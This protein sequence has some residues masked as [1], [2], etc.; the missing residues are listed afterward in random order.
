[1]THIILAICGVAS[2][3]Q[4]FE[5]IGGPHTSGIYTRACGNAILDQKNLPYWK[6]PADFEDT[7]IFNKEDDTIGWRIGGAYQIEIGDL[8]GVSLY[9]YNSK[10]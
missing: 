7:F 3:C 4:T 6:K 10:G 5:V 1:M 8:M 9:I 2:E